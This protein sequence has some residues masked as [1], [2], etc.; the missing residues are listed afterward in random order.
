MAHIVKSLSRKF[1]ALAVAKDLSQATVQNTPKFTL[2]SKGQKIPAKVLRITDGDTCDI[3]VEFLGEIYMIRVRL[4]GIDTPESHPPLQDPHR[5]ATVDAARAASEYLKDLVE[6]KM[7]F[8]DLA[9]TDKYGRSLAEIYL[10]EGAT[11]SVNEL[12][13]RSGHAVPYDGGTKADL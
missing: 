10:S 4:K 8:V 5:Q 2:S 7:V 3:A 11:E 13:I 12:L 9:D 6:G 1:R